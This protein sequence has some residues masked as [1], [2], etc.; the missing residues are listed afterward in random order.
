MKERRIRWV[1]DGLELKE[2]NFLRGEK[3][4]RLCEEGS[5]GVNGRDEG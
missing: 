2:I 5:E 4:E 1:S 3:K